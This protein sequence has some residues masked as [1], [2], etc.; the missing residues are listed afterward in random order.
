MSKP[1]VKTPLS[2]PGRGLLAV[3][4]ALLLLYSSPADAARFSGAYLLQVCE[5][6]E[7]GRETV[8]GGHATCQAYIAGVIDYHNVLSSLKIAPKV[9]ICIPQKVTLNQLHDVVLNYL[10]KH[11]EHDAFV[12]APAVTMALFEVYPCK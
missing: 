8:K 6:D 4:F 10:R 12:A 11:G 3:F 7:K 1:G 2:L 9:D 5:M